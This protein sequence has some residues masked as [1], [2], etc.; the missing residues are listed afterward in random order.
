MSVPGTNSTANQGQVLMQNLSHHRY[1]FGDFTLDI[2]RGCLLRGEGEVKIRP[3]SFAVLQHLVENSGRL[4]SKDQLIRAGWA[5]TAVTDDSLVKCLKDIRQALHD[6]AQE[7]I[8]TVPRRGYIFAAEVSEDTAAAPITPVKETSGV[9]LISERTDWQIIEGQAATNQ[10]G[11]TRVT[12]AIKRHWWVVAASLLALAIITTAAVYFARSGDVIDSIAVMPFVNVSNNADTD[13]LSD[14]IS[15]SVINSLSQLPNFKKVIPFSS[16]FRYKGKQIDPQSV[17]RELNVRAVLTGRLVLRGDDLLVSTELVDVKNNK[18]LWGEQ[19]NRRFADVV[20]LQSEIAQQ[21]SE[22]LRL[23]LTGEQ[24]ER[25]TKRYTENTEAYRLYLQG[26]YYRRKL[27]DESRIKSG[28]YFQKA[29]EKDPNFALGYAGLAGTYM[30]LALYGQ[31]PPKEAWQ[32]AEEAAVKALAIDDTLGEGHISLGYVK[33]RYD[34]DWPGAEREFK[35]AIELNPDSAQSHA[36]YANLLRCV[37][38]VDEAIAEAKRS[39]ELDPLSTGFLGETLYFAR[40]YDEAVAEV[41]K[42]VGTSRGGAG[43]YLELGEIYIQQGR[44]DE[45]LAEMLKARALV[46]RPRQL[47]RI[48]YVYA[49]AGKRDEAIKI[50]AEVKGPT[51]ERYDLA[52]Y[53]AD[54]YAA[55]G[56]KDQAFAWLEKACDQREQGVFDLKV[57]PRWDTL[58][59]DSRFTALLW[60]MKLAS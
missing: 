50:L 20:N 34:W 22:R 14:G 31:M 26:R 8:K 27:T 9:Q 51:T 56:D 33:M 58:R 28:E 18:L 48:G 16:V 38:R 23:K 24:K 60:R 53:I 1:F 3:K 36:G 17:G 45:A 6:E 21:I 35:R 4:I 55:L 29:I 44:Y 2:T 39:Q 41:Q 10:I 13:Y 37:G 46:E 15:D 5:D 47:A 12:S 42:E 54:I 57:G 52:G 11:F 30:T 59:S 25:L 7:I 49:A 43:T 19:Y 32:K 40:R